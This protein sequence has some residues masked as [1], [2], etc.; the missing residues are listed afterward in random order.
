MERLNAVESLPQESTCKH[1][2]PF[3]TLCEL[4]LE[5]SRENQPVWRTIE[6][7]KER[8][9][10][11]R[12]EE[13]FPTGFIEIGDKRFQIESVE[14]GAD[15][16]LRDVQNLFEKTFGAEEVDRED[17]LRNA[18]DG[19][20]PWGTPGIKY[21]IFTLKDSEGRLVSTLTGAQL[22]LLDA[23]GKPSGETAFFIGYAVTEKDIRQSGLAR[24]LYISALMRIAAE[25][26]AQGKKLKFAVGECKYQSERFWN[27]V[28]WKRAYAQTGDKKEYSELKYIQPALDFNE[29]TGEVA[30]DAGTAPEHLMVDAFGAEPPDKEAALKAVQAIYNYNN[31]WP[32]EAFSNEM[33][34]EKH[35]K[36]TEDLEREMK[37]FLDGSGQLI[38]LDFTSRQKARV[39]GVKIH[40]HIEADRGET[41]KEDF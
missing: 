22:D 10:F 34:Y 35:L 15:P 36:H 9:K 11:H 39:A 3:D 33:A 23:K 38:F 25:A 7:L 12:A 1:G 14:S 31:V 26:E 37:E 27:S 13:N 17:V 18:I 29:E 41:G 4:C 30:A 20:S 32:R 28:G 8:S 19:K 16:V 21:K 2:R 6:I 40:E 5:D 24:E